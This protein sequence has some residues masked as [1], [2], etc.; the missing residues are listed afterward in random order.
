M[1]SKTIDDSTGDS[2]VDGRVQDGYR[3]LVKFSDG[4]KEVCRDADDLASV[5]ARLDSALAT[6]NAAG[7]QRLWLSGARALEGTMEFDDET[8]PKDVIGE[9]RGKGWVWADR[10]D[11]IVYTR[12]DGDE[13]PEIAYQAA[14]ALLDAQNRAQAEALNNI[15][16]IQRKMIESAGQGQAPAPSEPGMSLIG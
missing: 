11:A 3:Y 6:G 16:E 14:A 8:P 9:V 2:R 5:T 10:V 13:A 7:R 1:G 4:T 15:Q 12:M